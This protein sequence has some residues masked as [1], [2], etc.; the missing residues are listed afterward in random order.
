MN[1]PV[2]TVTMGRGRG[3][4]G[5][6]VVGIAAG[7]MTTAALRAIVWVFKLL[8]DGFFEATMGSFHIGSTELKWSVG[9]LIVGLAYGFVVG[10][11]LRR[12]G[13]LTRAGLAAYPLF[14]AIGYWAAMNVAINTV[15]LNSEFP[16]A[17]AGALAG[18]CGAVILSALAAIVAP[19]L[20]R[21]PSIAI[22]TIVG[23]VAGTLLVPFAFPHDSGF[24]N[25]LAADLI[26]YGGWQ[27]AYTASLGFVL[28]PILVEPRRTSGRTMAA[29]WRGMVGAAR[30]ECS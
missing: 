25:N 6:A 15:Q 22:T 17:V 27:G 16:F 10:G 24:W 14:A 12:R 3:A 2:S 1:D 21:L 18:L 23:A 28:G 7:V 8:P 11:L 29:R 5:F 13:V 9:H 19:A 4:I 20:R 26:I 30:P